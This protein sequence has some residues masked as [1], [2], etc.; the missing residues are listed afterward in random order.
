MVPS[1][2]P[3]LHVASTSPG[4]VLAPEMISLIPNDFKAYEEL[5]R[6][7]A[8]SLGIQMKLMEENIHKLIDIFHPCVAEKVTL[9]INEAIMQPSKTLA[10]AET[11]STV[12]PVGQVD[13]TLSLLEE[14]RP[15]LLMKTSSPSSLKEVIT[16]PGELALEWETESSQSS[17]IFLH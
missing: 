14:P 6:R 5:L 15:T 3:L 16:P 4:K 7:L 12:A 2:L 17:G 9:L 11:V 10:V 1:H 13:R 8:A